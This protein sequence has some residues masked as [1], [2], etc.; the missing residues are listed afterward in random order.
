MLSFTYI[1]ILSLAI[2]ELLDD[3]KL[4][5]SFNR[6]TTYGVNDKGRIADNKEN[7]SPHRITGFFASSAS[8]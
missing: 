3:K 6:V 7:F 5:E 2:D 8:R 4:I 1:F